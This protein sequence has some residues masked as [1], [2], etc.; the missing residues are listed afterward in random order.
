MCQTARHSKLTHRGGRAYRESSNETLYSRTLCNFEGWVLTGLLSFTQGNI[1][2]TEKL[3]YDRQQQYEIQVTAWDCGQK[4]A[5]HSV[6][7]RIDVKPVCKPGWQGEPSSPE[8]TPGRLECVA[9][10]HAETQM[11]LFVCD[12]LKF[13]QR[14]RLC[15]SPDLLRRCSFFGPAE[16]QMWLFA[17][18]NFSVFDFPYL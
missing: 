15:A 3:S 16:T 13:V 9:F 14:V 8:R 12:L 7:V 6:P 4:R 11:R 18:H 1:R 2:N 5:L 10:Q 17:S